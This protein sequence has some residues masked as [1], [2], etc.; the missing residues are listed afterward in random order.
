MAKPKPKKV[1]APDTR[2]ETLPFRV[3]QRVRLKD[4]RIMLI[5]GYVHKDCNA[6]RRGGDGPDNKEHGLECIRDGEPDY[7]GK[8]TISVPWSKVE[9]V[10]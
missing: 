4:G 2:P 1:E 10:L 8:A 6:A 5:V 3:G 7:P 9:A